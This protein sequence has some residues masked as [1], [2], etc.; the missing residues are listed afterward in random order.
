M[1]INERDRKCDGC[2]YSAT[3]ACLNSQ[4]CD[5]HKLYVLSLNHGQI[6]LLKY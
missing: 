3:Y 6:N 4:K 2:K 1:K 5:D